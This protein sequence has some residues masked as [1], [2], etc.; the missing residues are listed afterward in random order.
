VKRR[1]LRI[2]T[3]AEGIES[4]DQLVLVRAPAALTRRGSCSGSR[5]PAELAFERFAERRSEGTAA[6]GN[7]QELG[8]FDED[9]DD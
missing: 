4:E 5:A 6:Y 2:A 9:M 1:S 7:I 8:S 3:V